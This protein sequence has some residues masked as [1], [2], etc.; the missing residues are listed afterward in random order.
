MAVQTIARGAAR[1]AYAVEPTTVLSDA[2]T[3]LFATRVTA[4]PVASLLRTATLARRMSSRLV[5]VGVDA[6][7]RRQ[8]RV[9]DAALAVWASRVVPWA[10]VETGHGSLDRALAHVSRRT[11][12]RLI[13]VPRDS[14]SSPREA[15]GLAHGCGAPVLVARPA[16]GSDAVVVAS[17]L[18]DPRA[19]VVRTAAAIAAHLRAPLCVVHNA[20]PGS[21]VRTRL[22]DVLERIGV[23]A[24][25]VLRSAPQTTDAVLH[26]ARAREADLLV[27]GSTGSH[28][29]SGV[30]A[31][32]LERARRSVLVMPL[33]RPRL[34]GGL[35]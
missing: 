13:V 8:R 18:R 30:A 17:D 24:D 7:T 20:E 3:I 9:D 10:T 2:S 14:L 21:R 28:P 15:I 31:E 12:P 6:G 33:G 25:A 19:P 26:E 35:V 1:S 22:H 29:R 16:A 27:V 5:L 32:V 34:G 11:T 4:R 23:H